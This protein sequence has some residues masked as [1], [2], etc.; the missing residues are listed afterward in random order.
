MNLQLVR[1]D[2]TDA[3]RAA[4]EVM[5]DLMISEFGIN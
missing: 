4:K 1:K 3:E 2:G 5:N